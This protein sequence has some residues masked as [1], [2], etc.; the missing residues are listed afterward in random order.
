MSQR[1]RDRRRELAM[2]RGIH[3]PSFIISARRTRR[4]TERARRLRAPRSAPLRAAPRPEA[5]RR[6]PHRLGRRA[7]R[8]AR[9]KK[10]FSRRVP[11]RL[12][13][14]AGRARPVSHPRRAVASGFDVTSTTDILPA[15]VTPSRGKSTS[16][17]RCDDSTTKDQ[18]A[19]GC[20][21]I[22]STAYYADRSQRP[23]LVDCERGALS[24][25]AKRNLPRRRN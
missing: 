23:D 9:H 15:R 24:D 13:A 20:G 25:A 18:I 12:A 2:N 3:S 6:N 19:S 1:I 8:E 4:R 7:H 22:G 10:G 21:G 11:R 16:G 14:G 5:A 17:Q